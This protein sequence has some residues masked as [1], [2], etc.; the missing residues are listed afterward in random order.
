MQTGENRVFFGRNHCSAEELHRKLEARG[1]RLLEDERGDGPAVTFGHPAHR[2]RAGIIAP[3]A[4]G[5]CTACNRLR[6]SASGDLRLCLFGER[7]IPLRPL[8]K[9][10]EQ[11]DELLALVRGSV[12]AKPAS[13]LLHQGCCGATP[14]L[15]ATGG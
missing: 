7:V 4:A 13:H 11:R 6:V 15:A 10:D 2:G 9:S 12:A 3:H 1:W 14:T 8:L 5:F